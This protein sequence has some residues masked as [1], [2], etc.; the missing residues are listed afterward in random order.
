[1][2]LKA[3]EIPKD[4][5]KSEKIQSIINQ[6]KKVHRD[7]NLVGIAAPQIGIS[8][9]I[10]IM[11]FGEKLKEKYPSDV[12]ENRQMSTLPLTVCMNEICI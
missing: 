2:R 10:I 8:Y 6:M 5:I 9:R 4:L 1:M 3:Q 11:E 7:Y 12:Y